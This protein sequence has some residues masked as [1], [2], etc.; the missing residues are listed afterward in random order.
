MQ[1]SRFALLSL[2]SFLVLMAGCAD[3]TR[4]RNTA[5]PAVP[6]ITLAQQVC[7]NCHGM[8]GVSVSPNFPELAGQTPDYLLGQ[9]QAFKSHGRQDPAGFE[10]MW[11]LSRHLSDAQ[12]QGLASYYAAQAPA[13]ARP[14]GVGDVHK[15]ESIFTGGIPDR[16]VPACTSCHGDKAQ[17]HDAFPRLAGQHADYVVKQLMV[18]QRTDERPAGAAMKVVAHEL[19]ETDMRD[20]A[21]YVQSIDTR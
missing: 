4:S 18:F 9:L 11:G 7:S 20:V 2:A 8:T 21:A 16:G 17:G 14:A 19:H 1:R 6:A 13:P 12:M 3:P 5:D 15:G 10:Y